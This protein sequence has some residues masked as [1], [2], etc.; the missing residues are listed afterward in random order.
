MPAAWK[1][2]PTGRFTGAPLWSNGA[3]LR[4]KRQRASRF[5][6]RT[7][8][9]EKRVFFSDKRSRARTEDARSNAACAPVQ[10]QCTRNSC[11]TSSSSSIPRPAP[12][13]TGTRPS[14]TGGRLATS[15]LISGLGCRQY[16]IRSP[17]GTVE[18]QCS[19]AARLM[20]VLKQCGTARRPW[21]FARSGG[22]W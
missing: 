6:M 16:S 9:A 11:S 4:S 12:V 3:I 20:P 19:E 1:L 15:F 8:R 18:I 22:R 14:M 7:R 5:G 21:S 17:S 13:G 2:P 10:S